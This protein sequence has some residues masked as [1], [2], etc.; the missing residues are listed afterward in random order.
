VARCLAFAL[1]EKKGDTVVTTMRP[2]GLTEGEEKLLRAVQ[3]GEAAD[4]RTGNARLDDPA[5]GDTS[6]AEGT[7]RSDLVCQLLLRNQGALVL[8]GARI[9]GGLNLETAMLAY[10][11]MLH[12]C[13]CHEPINLRDASVPLI[14]LTDCKLACL[15]A[16][17]L[18]TSG[19]LN[20]TGTTAT[21]GAHPGGNLILKRSTLTGGSLPGPPRRQS[22]RELHRQRDAQRWQSSDDDASSCPGRPSSG[23]ACSV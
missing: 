19:E 12:G 23:T 18:R 16:D 21:H 20:L 8:S 17:M 6:G 5:R 10:P 15:A 3:K 1:G 4:L 13:F 9:K 2:H 14:R 7:V 22:V 11:M